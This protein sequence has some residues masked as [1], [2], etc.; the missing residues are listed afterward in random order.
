MKR[1][2]VEHALSKAVVNTE[3]P[4]SDLALDAIVTG[5][6]VEETRPTSGSKVD[7][8]WPQHDIPL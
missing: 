6:P 3:A 8:V 2:K 1:S 7:L 5:I 4:P